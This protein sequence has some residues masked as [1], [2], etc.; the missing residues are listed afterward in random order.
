ML[1]LSLNAQV[2]DVLRGKITDENGEGIPGVIIVIEEHPRI[3]TITDFDGFYNLEFPDRFFV[4]TIK[5]LFTGMVA[6]RYKI[7]RRGNEVVI[8][9]TNR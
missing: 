5:I 4:F 2:T 1:V 9:E 7:D 8:K 6:K 3:K